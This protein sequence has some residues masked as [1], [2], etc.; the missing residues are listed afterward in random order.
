MQ[1]HCSVLTQVFDKVRHKS[2]ILKFQGTVNIE[3]MI[4]NKVNL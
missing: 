4:C 1:Q 3:D 2:L